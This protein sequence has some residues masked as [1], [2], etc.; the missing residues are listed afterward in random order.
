M[1]FEQRCWVWLLWRWRWTGSE[2]CPLVGAGYYT[3]SIC[4]QESSLV[5][6]N[7]SWQVWVGDLLRSCTISSKE[8]FQECSSHLGQM[9]HSMAITHSSLFKLL[10]LD[11]LPN[12]TLLGTQHSH[13]SHHL[14]ALPHRA[15][16]LSRYVGV[17]LVIG[18]FFAYVLAIKK[19]SRLIRSYFFNLLRS[20]IR[21]WET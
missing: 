8:V 6:S 17:V 2:L 18:S 11:M 13:S 16:L 9:H 4:P 15:I 5:G 12:R 1:W 21:T 10:R 19:K 7:W 14:V 20:V 3:C